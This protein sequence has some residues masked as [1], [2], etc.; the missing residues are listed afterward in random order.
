MFGTELNQQESG[1][2]T[3]SRRG[4]QWA[5][6]FVFWQVQSARVFC[7]HE[8]HILSWQL[9][10]IHQVH[11]ILS[12]EHAKAPLEALLQV[13][14]LLNSSANLFLYFSLIRVKILDWYEIFIR[15]FRFFRLILLSCCFWLRLLYWLIWWFKL[16]FL[17]RLRRLF[18]FVFFIR[19]VVILDVKFLLLVNLFPWWTKILITP[20]LVK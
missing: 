1:G 12:E 10:L 6:V 18:F 11:W 17:N 20:I 5:V 14:R 19:I 7:A 13:Y 4:L 15:E 2:R 9:L 8:I 3:R 16:L